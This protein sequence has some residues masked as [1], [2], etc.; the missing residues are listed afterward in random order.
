MHFVRMKGTTMNSVFR[1]G[2]LAALC[3][4]AAAGASAGTANVTFV[5]PQKFTDV[6]FSSSE[7]ERVL[8][9]LRRHFDKL[10]AA[11]PANQQLNVEV[12]DVDLAGETWPARM[13]GEDIRIMKGGAD[14][15]RITLRYSITQN[16]QVI[17]RGE[18]SLSDMAYQQHTTRYGGDDP[19]R[20]EK[21]MLDQWFHERVAAR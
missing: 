5:Q 8:Q 3:L 2:A 13:R 6:P 12:T 11:L 16:G 7:R 10:A 19:L 1:Q 17:K 15:P 20:Y 9:D 18:D 21:S 4:L 14:W